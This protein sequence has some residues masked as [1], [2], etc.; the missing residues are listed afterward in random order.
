M[1]ID[2]H[3]NDRHIYESELRALLP[4]RLFD[5]H[6]HLFDAASRLPGTTWPPKSC[7]LKFGGAFTRAA[8]LDWAK[9]WLPEQELHLNSFGWP[10]RDQDRDRAATYSG[11][12]SDNRRFFGLALVAPADPIAAVRARVETNGLVGYKPYLD[13]VEGKSAAEITIADLLSPAQ[14]DYANERGLAIMLHIPRPGRLTDPLNQSQMVAL[15]RRYPRARIIFAHIGRAYY[16]RNVRGGLDGIAA[17][18]NAYLDTAMVNHEGVLA[19]AF[20]HFPLDRILVGSDAPIACLRGKSVEINNQYAYLMGEDYEIG[21][22][23][24][25]TGGAIQFTSF[26]YEQLR[27][28]L[29]AAESA[30]LTPAQVADIFFNNAHKLFSAIIGPQGPLP[31]GALTP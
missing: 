11:A 23:I 2:Y 3:D 27:G 5:A 25:D 12:I 28:I 6:V 7:G 30:G 29:L 15:C 10:A 26:Y 4:A 17:C 24:H 31:T 13:F 18:P 1:T 21:T 8:Y 19:Y 16:L 14:L 22:S 9:T 20:R